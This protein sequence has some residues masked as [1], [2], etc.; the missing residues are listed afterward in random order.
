MEVGE[1]I[2]PIQ[3]FSKLPHVVD[4]DCMIVLLK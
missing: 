1:S 4:L 3:P 2:Q